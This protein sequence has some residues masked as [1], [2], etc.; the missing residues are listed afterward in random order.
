MESTLEN[1][2]SN[3]IPSEGETPRDTDHNETTPFLLPT[4]YSFVHKAT[5]HFCFAFYHLK[6]GL[7][8]G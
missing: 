1:S 7:G 3:L 8:P 5:V 6:Q 2:F 4:K